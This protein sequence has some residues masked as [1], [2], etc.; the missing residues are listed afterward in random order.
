MCRACVGGTLFGSGWSSTQMMLGLPHAL[1]YSPTRSLLIPHRSSGKEIFVQLLPPSCALLETRPGVLL[2]GNTALCLGSLSSSSPLFLLLLSLSLPSY[3][4]SFLPPPSRGTF[5]CDCTG[6]N[7]LDSFAQIF[8]R[9]LKRHTCKSRLPQVAAS[10]VFPA[11]ENG[12]AS[13]SEA[14]DLGVILDSPLFFTL[15]MPSLPLKS[16]SSLSLFCAVAQSH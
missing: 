3:P 13:P 8:H 16:K 10:S 6:K 14:P 4:F 7:P 11:S 5:W 12:T 9:H 1:P 15:L 2:P